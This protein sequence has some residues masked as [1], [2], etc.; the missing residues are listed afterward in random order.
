MVRAIS[1]FQDCSGFLLRIQQDLILFAKGLGKRSRA[2]IQQ[3]ITRLRPFCNIH[4]IIQLGGP[5]V[6]YSLCSFRSSLWLRSRYLMLKFGIQC[7][8]IIIKTSRPSL[9][10]VCSYAIG[11]I[12]SHINLSASA[13]GRLGYCAPAVLL[14][15]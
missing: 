3:D 11:S 4:L 10:T 5:I 9:D 13:L 14:L 12:S 2:P 7:V 1:M 6:F 15:G 8:I